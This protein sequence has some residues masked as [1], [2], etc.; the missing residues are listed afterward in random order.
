V[1]IREEQREEAQLAGYT[2]VDLSTV[3]ATHIAEVIKK[4]AADLL[5]RQEVQRLLDALAATS[6]KAVE[7]VTDALPLGIIQKVLQNLVRE[8]VSIRDLLTI[9][10]ALA[11]YAEMTKDPEILTEYVRQRMGRAIVKPFLDEEDTLHVITLDSSIEEQ[12]RNSLQQT[13]HGVFLS[14]DPG[15]AQNIVGAVKNAVEEALSRGYQP[16]ILTN[17]VIRRHLRRLIERFVPEAAVLSHSEV[18]GNVRLE[19]IS[20]ISLK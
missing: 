11:D 2:V 17:P 10:E 19:S 14:L 5:G 16:V 9:S 15:T 8:N 20:V 13:E 6:P 3:I 4:N 7:E 18:P 1:W 12:I